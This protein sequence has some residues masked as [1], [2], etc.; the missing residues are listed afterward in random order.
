MYIIQIEKQEDAGYHCIQS[1]SHRTACWQEG[2]IAV[3]KE[4][5]Q[6]VIES[7][8]YCDLHIENNVLVNV[9]LTPKSQQDVQYLLLDHEY[10]LALIEL[11]GE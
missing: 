11:R 9:A 10:R 7:E 6:V 1:Q 8:G 5:E 4:L 2:Y 3:P